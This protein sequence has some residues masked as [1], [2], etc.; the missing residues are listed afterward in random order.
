MLR[1]SFLT[2]L[3]FSIFVSPLR[4]EQ[5]E[6][7]LPKPLQEQRDRGAQIF[8]LGKYETLDGWVMVR[9]S[10]PEFYY[11]TPDNKA[12]IMGFL[13][14]GDG[15]LL[16]GEQLKAL[17]VSEKTDLATMVA[18][19]MNLPA[20]MEQGSLPPPV[21][22]VPDESN[23]N[24]TIT[25][26][27]RLLQ[28]MQ[29]APGLMLGTADKPTFYAFIDPGCAHCNYFLKT[30]EPYVIENKV[31]VQIV[32]VGFNDS[33]KQQAAFALSASDGAK[34]F[35]EHAKG[36]VEILPIQPNI[37]VSAIETNTKMMSNWNLTGTPI[38]L[39]KSAASGE[40]KIIRG[41]PLE[42]SE[43]IADLTGVQ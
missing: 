17:N 37:N 40:I 28:E 23:S 12:L 9:A 30:I 39:Y 14:S 5:K 4:A 18:P 11:A 15:E 20:K 3:V 34:R 16:T 43:V 38:I 26:S 21:S 19:K 1:L 24:K 29:A 2:L 33:S 10:Q 8:Y 41:R 31:S 35:L 42:L 32:P 6:P 27:Q 7:P 13:F 25:A 22:V 36:N